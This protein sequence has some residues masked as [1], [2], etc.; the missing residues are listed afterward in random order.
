MPGRPPREWFKR[1]FEDVAA[2]GTARIPGAVC[3]QAWARKTDAQKRRTV[4]EEEGVMAKKK[5]KTK[6]KSHH[7]KRAA[8]RKKKKKHHGRKRC[9]Y[10]GHSSRHGAAGCTHTS[11][12]GMF[13]PCKH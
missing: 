9:G 8:P 2:K 3:G 13:C 1:C 11:A 12:G 4:R 6:K 10:C 5:K 7:A